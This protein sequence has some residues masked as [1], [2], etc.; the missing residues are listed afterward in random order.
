MSVEPGLVFELNKAIAD[1]QLVLHYQPIV[2]ISDRKLVAVEA[3]VRWRHRQRGI[4]PPSEFIPAIERAGLANELTLWVLREAI[5]QSSVWKTDR[6]ALSVGLNLSPENL[7]D[8]HFLRNLEMTLRAFGTR[9]LL[10]AEV[11]GSRVTTPEQ[12]TGLQELRDRGIRVNLD[13]VSAPIDLAG[14]PADGVKIG[15]SLVAR[16]ATDGALEQATAIVR[17]AKALGRSVTAVGIED[18]LT[19]HALADLGCDT[20][21]GFAIAAPMSNADLSKWRARH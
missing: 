14:V 1:N 12:L 19:W 16:L 11:P 13:D 15:R 3:L 9:D 4:L 21:Q 6:E 20:A 2:R 5:L 8:A 7:T 17:A 10:I 18:E